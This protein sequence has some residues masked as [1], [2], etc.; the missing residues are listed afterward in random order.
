MFPLYIL[1]IKEMHGCW[2]RWSMLIILEIHGYCTSHPTKLLFNFLRLDIHSTN[3]FCVSLLALYVLTHILGWFFHIFFIV[4]F[5]SLSREFYR[6]SLV[7]QWFHTDFIVNSSNFID[8]FFDWF[9]RSMWRWWSILILEF[10][11]Y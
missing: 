5:F 10:Y 3:I 11:Q 8:F 4:I 6:L 9:F 7:A 1:H 2:Y